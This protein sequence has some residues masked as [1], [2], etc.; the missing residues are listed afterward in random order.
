[1]ASPHTVHAV[2]VSD[3]AATSSI[4]P[5]VLKK[6]DWHADTRLESALAHV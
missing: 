3:V 1:M 4:V 6:P 5:A 2:H